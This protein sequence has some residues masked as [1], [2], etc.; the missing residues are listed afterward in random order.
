MGGVQHKKIII[1]WSNEVISPDLVLNSMK[2]I[3]VWVVPLFVCLF[4]LF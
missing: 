1:N 4:V 2:F 3:P